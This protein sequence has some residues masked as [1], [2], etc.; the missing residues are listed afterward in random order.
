MEG[1]KEIKKAG[2]I[3]HDIL[4]QACARVG[5]D[6]PYSEI[7][8]FVD[9]AIE[10]AGAKPAFPVNI[11]VNEVA[12]HYSPDRNEDKL[13]EKGDVVKIDLGVH[14]DGYPSDTASTVIVGEN[15]KGEKLKKAAEAALKAAGE[16][17]KPG[18]S[19][20]EVGKAIGNVI[21]SAGFQPIRNLTGHSMARWNLHS[22][23]SVFNF[24]A[25]NEVIE[26]D[27]L[28]AIEPFSTDGAG[29][30]LESKPSSIYRLLAPVPQRLPGAK[31]LL[32]RIVNDYETFPFAQRWLE[33]KELLYLPQL[34]ASGA[35]HRYPVLMEKAKGLVA[36]SEHTFLVGE[37][38]V[39]ITT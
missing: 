20:Q 14:V 15:P 3:A 35:V 6:V 18:R 13:F 25:P 17:L 33:A 29:K 28:V 36:Q 16:A 21:T 39:E 37:K 12:A 27:T 5:E 1:I 26:P 19:L 31:K 22:G 4:K 23:L 8:D 32:Q 38:D 2:T 7:S 11:S 10:K 30:I 34:V 24:D 9:K